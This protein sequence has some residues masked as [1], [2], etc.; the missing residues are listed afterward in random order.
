MDLTSIDQ[1]KQ[2]LQEKEKLFLLIYKSGS[3]QSDCARERVLHAGTQAG[4]Q[5]VFADVNQVK[6]IHS[7]YGITTAPSLLEFSGQKLRNVTRGCQSESWYSA[8]LSGT[9]FTQV[10]G[11]EG[12]PAKRVTVYTT[13]TC[14]WC[15]TIKTYFREKN[16]NFTEVNV[17]AD[18]ARAEEMVRKSGQQGVPQTDINGQVVVGFDKNRINELL[19]IR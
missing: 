12:K 5:V 6:D 2:A 7:A 15:N 16:V 17:A 11:K 4:I 3:D 14:T 8:A 13:P 19:E 1:L 9:G 18:P 10:A